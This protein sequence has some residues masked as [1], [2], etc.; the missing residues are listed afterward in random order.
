MTRLEELQM[1]M[2]ELARYAVHTPNY[3]EE[4]A[5]EYYRVLELHRE[6]RIRVNKELDEKARLRRAKE[7]ETFVNGYGEATHREITSQTYKNQQKRL[8]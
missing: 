3:D 5:K 7:K 4:K 1:K 8:R 6:E 2:I